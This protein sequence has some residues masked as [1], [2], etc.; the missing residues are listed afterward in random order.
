MKR[1]LISAAAL[2]VLALGTVSTASGRAT[3]TTT[4]PSGSQVVA[5]VII[6]VTGDPVTD[7]NGNVWATA[8]YTRTLIV[9]R[10]T[11][12]TYCATWR[13]TG[14]FTTTGSQSPGGTGD[15]GPGITG[16]LTRTG[17]TNTFTATWQPSAATSGTLTPQA[18]P[19]DW[20]SPYFSDVQ[21]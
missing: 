5:N 8:T 13:D 15:L 6:P 20:P 2:C 19:F 21:G 3:L 17:T 16:T 4:C 9:F 7:A 1:A 12:D 11:K 14:T 18:G 10:V